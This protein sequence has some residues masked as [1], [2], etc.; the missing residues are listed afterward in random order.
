MAE[1]CVFVEYVGEKILRVSQEAVSE[2]VRHAGKLDARCTALVLGHRIPPKVLEDLRRFGVDRVLVCEDESLS[3]YSTERYTDCLE[4]IL[5]KQVPD[6]LLMGSSALARDL[7]PRVSARLGCG[8]VTEATFLNPQRGG[9]SPG[10]TPP[11]L[12]PPRL[13]D[14]LLPGQGARHCHAGSQDRGG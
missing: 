7:A 5:K 14:F 4:Q 12:P 10:P 8:L 6:V 1:I 13:H 2:A 11:R 3:E 9:A